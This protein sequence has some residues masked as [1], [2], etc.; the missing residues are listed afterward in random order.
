MTNMGRLQG[1][2]A[3]LDSLIEAQSQMLDRLLW[4]QRGSRPE[5]M[6]RYPASL[7]QMQEADSAQQTV[8][9]ASSRLNELLWQ[10][11]IKREILR[12]LERANT[13]SAE[14]RSI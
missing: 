12:L 4:Q 8:H 6:L 2:L 9:Q 11:E 13:H 5:A 14:A 1:E 3:A 10:R 7:K